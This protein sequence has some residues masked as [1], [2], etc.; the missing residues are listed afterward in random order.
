M[1]IINV[2]DCDLKGNEKERENFLCAP[3]IWGSQT[4]V[5]PQPFLSLSLALFNSLFME[6]K[7]RRTHYSFP[8]SLSADLEQC[9]KYGGKLDFFSLLLVFTLSSLFSRSEQNP[10]QFG[11][12]I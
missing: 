1:K 10:F 3:E 12:I 9:G 8:I 6:L 11:S 2:D 7:H 4:R 5:L